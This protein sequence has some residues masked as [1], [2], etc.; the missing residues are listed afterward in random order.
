MALIN[1]HT[2]GKK[3]KKRLV[4]NTLVKVSS[5]LRVHKKSCMK[6][7]SKIFILNFKHQILRRPTQIVCVVQ[8]K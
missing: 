8:R 6:R 7:M 4:P 2:Q 1:L 3:K 5:Q